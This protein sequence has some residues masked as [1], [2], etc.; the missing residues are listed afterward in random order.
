VPET[1]IRRFHVR[2][3]DQR[4]RLR[5]EE[6]AVAGFPTRAEA[7][8]ALQRTWTIFDPAMREC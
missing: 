5:L 1:R 2:E 6:E 8:R 7:E 4:W 3:G